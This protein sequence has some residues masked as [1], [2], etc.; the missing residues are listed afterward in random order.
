[1]TGTPENLYAE[2]LAVYYEGQGDRHS[3]RQLA[4]RLSVSVVESSDVLAGNKQFF[5]S[6]RQGCLKLLDREL[7]KQG[8]LS[9]D[10]EPRPGE[11]R[12]WPASRQG[13]LAQALGRKT[14]TVID[15]TAGWGQDSLAIFRM[16]YELLCLERSPVMYELLADGFRRLA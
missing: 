2:K 1:M 7:L 14:R 5:L 4:D 11:Q 13:L 10:I 12:S 6:W 9:V 16:G 8:G 3:F 15:A